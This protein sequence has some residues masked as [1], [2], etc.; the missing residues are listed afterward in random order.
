MINIENATYD[1]E[2]SETIVLKL[3]TS[4]MFLDRDMENDYDEKSAVNIT[5]NV[6]SSSCE[7][8]AVTI[9]DE[10]VTIQD[11]GTYVWQKNGRVHVESMPG[12]G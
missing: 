5:L 10:V 8:S 12:F 2:K 9:N 6:G 7:D 1:N 11:E 3:N 4:D